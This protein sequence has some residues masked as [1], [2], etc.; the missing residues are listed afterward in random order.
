MFDK[1]FRSC[2][3]TIESTRFAP[4]DNPIKKPPVRF[5]RAGG[6]CSFWIIG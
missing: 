4:H 1:K 2:N 6:F 5:E 3:M